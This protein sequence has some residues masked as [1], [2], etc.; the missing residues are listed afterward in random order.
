VEEIVMLHSL[1]DAGVIVEFL[2]ARRRELLETF[3]KGGFDVLHVI[4]HGTFGG[5]LAADGSAVRME[6]GDLRAAELSPR[7]V[8]ALRGAAPLIFFNT[9]HSG[10]IGFSLT[11]LGSWG[12]RLVELGCGG[13]VGTLWPVTDEAAFVFAQAFYELMAQGLPIGEVMLR[14][15]ERVHLRF[16]DDPTWL[17]YCC[18]ADPWARIE[19]QTHLQA[20]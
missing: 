16:P 13:F 4:S 10:R 6:D 8:G 12:A 11:R 20:E 3:E 2:P 14:A 19:R 1:E 5:T 15:R 17:A 18:F 9:C 7:I